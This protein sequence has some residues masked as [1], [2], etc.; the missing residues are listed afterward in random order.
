[1]CR[2]QPCG[3]RAPRMLGQIAD[4]DGAAPSFRDRMIILDRAAGHADRADH[5]AVSVNDWKAAREGNE[6]VVRMFDAE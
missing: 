4:A 2:R 1:M 6:P 5:D 3:S